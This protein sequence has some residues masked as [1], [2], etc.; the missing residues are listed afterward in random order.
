MR[1]TLY[2]VIDPEQPSLEFR[3]RCALAIMAKL[4]HAGKVKTR[5]SP[6]LNP[7]QAAALNAAFLKDTVACL[8]EVSLA[9]PATPVVSFTPRG[10]EA[11]FQGVIPS[12]IVLIPQRGNS[13]G[14]RLRYTADDLLAVGFGAVCLIDSDSPTVPAGAYAEAVQRLLAETDCAVLGP[15]DDGGYYLLGLNSV[16]PRLFEGIAWSTEI[17]ADQTRQR[18]GEIGMPM[19]SLPTWFDV[20]DRE[21]LLRLYRECITCEPDHQGFRAPHTRRFLQTIG[22]QLGEELLSASQD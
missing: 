22:R 20:D 1:Q 15:S 13:F 6:P 2:R 9:L 8:E 18:A 5:L 19:Y 17:V 12:H 4:P 16:P 21:T 7:E 10:E 3:G 14:E 11:G